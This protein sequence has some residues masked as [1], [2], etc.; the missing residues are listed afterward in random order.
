MI[1]VLIMLITMASCSSLYHVVNNTRPFK[2]AKP[3]AQSLGKLTSY[4]HFSPYS[5]VWPER[6]PAGADGEPHGG[7]IIERLLG[8]YA[9]L[10]S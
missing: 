5:R 6:K 1:T 10:T 7:C 4:L 2:S 9:V 8:Y 3:E